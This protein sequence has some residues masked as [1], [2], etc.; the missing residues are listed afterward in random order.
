M[1]DKT[2]QLLVFG[3]KT[4]KITVPEDAKITFGPWSPPAKG[5][6]GW[7]EGEK[8]GTLRIYKGTK[9][10]ILACFAHVS[11]FRD[12][13]LGYMEQIAKE[14]G[15]TVWKDD[16]KGYVRED[17]RSV[18]QEWVQPQIPVSVSAEKKKRTNG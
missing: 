11:G 14:E 9:D 7:N 5:R 12:L 13:S 16:E 3:Q 10:N 18:Q 15:A 2:K 4:F 8:T 6:A 17:K 1:S